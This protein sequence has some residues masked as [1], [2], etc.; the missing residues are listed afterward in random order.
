MSSITTTGTT[1]DP[2]STSRQAGESAGDWAERHGGRVSSATPS[3]D[4]LT[5]TW[6]SAGGDQS[7]ATHRRSGESDAL[8]QARHILEF[9]AAMIDQ[10]PV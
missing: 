3:G 5:T 1:T 10:P 8:F 2:V 9:T 6:K 7:K 4:T